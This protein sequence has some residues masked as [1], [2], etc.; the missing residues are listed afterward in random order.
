M[1]LMLL[2]GAPPAIAQETLEGLKARATKGDYTAQRDLAGC[3][4]EEA[5]ECPIQPQPS[6]VEA[7]T[8]RMIIVTS[9][10]TGVTDT[11]RE[12]YQRDCGFQT[13]SQLE[14]AAALVEA[15]RLFSGIYQRDLPVKRLLQTDR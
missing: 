6:P 13:I 10:H 7:C 12:A 4:G 1:M 3:L 9:E 5:G 8:W 11:D 2:L 15:Q 14:Q